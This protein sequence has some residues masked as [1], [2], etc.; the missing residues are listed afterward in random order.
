[1]GDSKSARRESQPR[2][3]PA[4]DKINEEWNIWSTI[5]QSIAEE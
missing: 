1:M 4:D 2:T 3:D 5:N